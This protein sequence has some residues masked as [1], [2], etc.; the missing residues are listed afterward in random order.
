MERSY[1]VSPR[2]RSGSLSMQ[3]IG[4][5]PWCFTDAHVEVNMPCCTH[6]PSP[7]ARVNIVFADE[8]GLIITIIIMFIF[9][10]YL[11]IVLT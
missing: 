10:C 8:E 7:S 5:T 9:N 6:A 11:H 3:L 1:H 4:Y 2:E